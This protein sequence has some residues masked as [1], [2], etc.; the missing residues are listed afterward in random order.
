MGIL[1]TVNLIGTLFAADT[2]ATLVEARTVLA[3]E[4]SPS[5]DRMQRLPF[6]YRLEGLM[7]ITKLSHKLKL[8]PRTQGGTLPQ[9]G[10]DQVPAPSKS[11]DLGLLEDPEGV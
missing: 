8:Q 7:A 2:E 11:R 1:P 6:A 3:K 10:W 9:A 5:R 4:G